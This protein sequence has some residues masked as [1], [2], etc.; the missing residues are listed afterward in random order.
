MRTLLS[1]HY[2]P[3]EV[4]TSDLAIASLAWGFN[5]GF[6]WLTA[7]AAVKQT[8]KAYLRTG[9][10]VLRNTYLRLI[11]G[12]LIVSLGFGL[13]CYLHLNDIIPPSFV[14]YFFILT[15][16]ALQV[17]FL[18]QIIINRCAL[19][20]QDEREIRRL[21]IG[22]A[23]F[24]TAI[25]VTVYAI[26]IPARLQVSPEY[27][28]INEWWDRCEKCLYLLTDGALNFY[29]IRTV[30]RDL[31]K[32]GLDKYKGLVRFN[33]FIVGFSL[34]MDVLI[35]SMMSLP[36]TFVYMQ[37]HPFAYTV[38]LK[39]EMSMA[40]LI[41]KIARGRDHANE[42]GLVLLG[43]RMGARGSGSDVPTIG[44][45]GKNKFC[46]SRRS[47]QQQQ[48]QQHRNHGSWIGRD[49]EV[50]DT[51]KG[52][53]P[54]QELSCLDSAIYLAE[55]GSYTTQELHIEFASASRVSRGHLDESSSTDSS[56]AR[57][58]AEGDTRS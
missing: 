38:K 58:G 57:G 55:R 28:W 54:I 49:D 37:F 36:N 12:E 35:I 10:L 19:L 4:T 56:A 6:G 40:D 8:R 24:I 51:R 20:V 22:V 39:I 29:F 21:K 23:T 50:V 33:M 47:P 41:V 30:Q 32:N 17:H 16:W 45:A 27:L 7:W 1:P 34:S 3:Q 2:V 48:Q 43:N 11:W 15:L 42:G 46:T 25:N 53:Q 26:W 31:V 9:R 44:S 5:I 52:A 18:L 14:F 13:I